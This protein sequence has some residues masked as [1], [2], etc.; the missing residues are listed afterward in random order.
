MTMADADKDSKTEQPT[1]KRLG[2][3]FDEGNFPK[4]PEIGVVF[5]LAASFAYLSLQAPALAASVSKFATWL[6]GHLNE[7]E[8]TPDVAAFLVPELF[9]IGVSILIPFLV[10]CCAA[11][12]LAGGLQTGFRITGKVLGFKPDKLNPVTGLQRLFSTAKFV[13]MGI[14]LLKFIVVTWILYGVIVDIRHDPIFY[15]MVSAQHIVEFIFKT[16]MEML[17]KMIL[18]IGVIAALNFSYHK[19]QHMENLKMTKQEVEDEMKNAEG[20]PKVKGARRKRAR[21]LAYRQV[22]S[23][24]PLAD[25]VVTNP[26][27]F[28]VALKYERGKDNAPVVL[29]KGKDL[30]AQRIKQIAAQ[31]EVPMIENRPVAQALYRES[32]VGRAI[33]ASLYQAVAQILAFVYRTHRYYFHRL[34]ARRL[35]ETA[36]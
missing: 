8:I 11:A 17:S 6:F 2:E 4:A 36:Q 10:V 14:S 31:N 30:L 27:H 35:L 16:F 24:V 32:V 15:T 28:A 18:V 9:K 33:P 5:I 21:Q 34:K 29:A 19:W 26:T 22:L 1:A 23:K 13:E 7:F 3:A 12:I 20:N 25:V